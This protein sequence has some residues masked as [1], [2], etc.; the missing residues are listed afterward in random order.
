MGKRYKKNNHPRKRKKD[1]F[2]LR[3]KK[4]N[5]KIREFKKY[6]L[7][8]E[9]NDIDNYIEAN[10]LR[11]EI[12]NLLHTQ[13]FFISNKSHRRRWVYYDQV[14]Q[15]KGL[16]VSWKKESLPTF[17]KVKYDCPDSVIPELCFFYRQVKQGEKPD[18]NIFY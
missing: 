2:I 6:R 7:N 18:Y 16:Y 10:S 5:K 1:H 3:E 17:F 13:S 12:K 15:F 11:L 9:V 14:S 4:I 8:K